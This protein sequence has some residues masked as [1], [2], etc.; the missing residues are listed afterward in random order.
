MRY[1]VDEAILRELRLQT[2]WLRLLGLQA[3]R[4]LLEQLLITDKQRTVFEYSDGSRSVREVAALAGVGT[5]TVSRLW[6]EWLAVGICAEVEST[7]G[8]A[9]HLV[10]LSALGLPLP[11]SSSS[12]DEG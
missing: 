10:A 9:R 1:D 4:P 2:G 5:S 11:G 6:G 3:L 8:R 12:S 7:A